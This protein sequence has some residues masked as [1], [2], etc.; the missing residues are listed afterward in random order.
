MNPPLALE[1]LT[2]LGLAPA[3][4]V[5]IAAAAGFDLVGIR[6]APADP[7][8]RLPDLAVGGPSFRELASVLRDTG[9]SVLDIEVI[10]IEEATVPDDYLRALEV[11]A[12]LGATYANVVADDAN[13]DRLA[14]T[15]A[16]LVERSHE[17]GIVPA[18]EPM[19][20][21]SVSTLA[22]A[23]SLAERSGISVQLDSL[24]LFRCGDST[25]DV[26]RLDPA[27]ISYLQLSDAP[28]NPAK[29]DPLSLR[30]EGRCSRLLPGEGELDLAGLLEV[31]PADITIAAE[32]PSQRMRQQFGDEEYARRIL[33]ATR[34][35]LEAR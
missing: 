26:D 3:A 9:V 24:H 30:R 20:W 19:A 6:V 13:D 23:D 27:H 31:L 17:F 12:S 8:E 4:F 28:A 32:I 11:G 10:R 1:Y 16:K 2:F 5:R 34:R 22:A 18:L 7:D 21:K 33:G 25:A 15:L 29:S 35:V 14:E